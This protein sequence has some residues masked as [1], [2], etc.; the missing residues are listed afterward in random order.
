MSAY[1]TLNITR[2]D[3]ISLIMSDLINADDDK[4]AD[5]AFE[6]W[7]RENLRNFIIVRSYDSLNEENF[8]GQHER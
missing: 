6:A 2:E 7:G 8:R 5:M 4:L 1:S 3:A